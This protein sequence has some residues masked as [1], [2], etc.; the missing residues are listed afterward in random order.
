MGFKVQHLHIIYLHIHHIHHLQL[1]EP[2]SSED[3]YF[4]DELYAKRGKKSTRIYYD[5]ETSAPSVISESPQTSSLPMDTVLKSNSMSSVEDRVGMTFKLT[6]T[7]PGIC[8][9]VFEN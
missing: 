2:E 5:S 9:G 3:F 8:L 6:T 1:K 7:K 4:D